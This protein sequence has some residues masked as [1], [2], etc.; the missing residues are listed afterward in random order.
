M[1]Q[2]VR[3]GFSVLPA[4][5]INHYRGSIEHYASWMW[6]MD[7]GQ[8]VVRVKIDKIP[9]KSEPCKAMNRWP[10]GS[11]VILHRG[12]YCTV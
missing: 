10:K 6:G 2:N 5:L 8:E 11:I 1:L 9:S 4:R 7:E 3:N 12:N